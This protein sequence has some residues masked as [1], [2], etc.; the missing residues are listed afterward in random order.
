MSLNKEE[1]LQYSQQIIL[2]GFGVEA[3]QKL[4]N[5]KVLVIRLWRTWKPRIIIS[6]CRRNWRIRNS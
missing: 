3:Q 6:S 5:A 4:K 2:P 1:L